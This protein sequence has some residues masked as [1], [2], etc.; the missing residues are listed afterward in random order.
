MSEQRAAVCWRSRTSDVLYRYRRGVDRRD[1]AMIRA[2][3]TLDAS[4]TTASTSAMSTFIAHVES[5]LAG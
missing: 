1:Y 3:I 4:T 5:N 2:C